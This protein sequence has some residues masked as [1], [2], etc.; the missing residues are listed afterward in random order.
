MAT[1]SGSSRR[2]PIAKPDVERTVARKRAPRPTVLAARAATRV[3]PGRTAD[4]RHNEISETSDERKP[5]GVARRCPRRRGRYRGRRRLRPD[6]RTRGGTDA[7][8]LARRRQGYVDWPPQLR[9]RNADPHHN[10]DHLRTRPRAVCP[11][12]SACLSCYDHHA[13]ADI[14]VRTTRRRRNGNEHEGDLGDR[15]PARCRRGD[16]NHH[17]VTTRHSADSSDAPNPGRGPSERIEASRFSPPTARGTMKQAAL[18]AKARCSAA[19]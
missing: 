15:Q 4:D 2:L 13:H 7:R 11:T 8:R 5:T 16:P 19:C 9:R 6:A 12:S 3:T 17:E 1:S 10:R 14:T 18:S